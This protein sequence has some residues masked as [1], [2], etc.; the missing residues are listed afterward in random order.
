MK[1]ALRSWLTYVVAGALFLVAA[2]IAI[3]PDIVDNYVATMEEWYSHYV[4]LFIG[5]ALIFIGFVWQDLLKAQHRRKTKNWDGPFPQD[6]SDRAWM[7]SLPFY[8]A[9]LLS[10]IGGIF[11]SFSPI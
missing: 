5:I 2:G 4:F 9:G 11:F 10:A 6:I 1:K 7:I 3:I 8:I